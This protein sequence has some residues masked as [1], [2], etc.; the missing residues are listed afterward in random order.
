MEHFAVSRSI[1]SLLALLISGIEENTAN[2]SMVKL[3]SLMAKVR[4]S[5][6]LLA[7]NTLA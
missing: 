7:P 1:V 6:K 3:L 4:L 5:L 2:A